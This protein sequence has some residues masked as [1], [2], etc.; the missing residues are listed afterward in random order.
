MVAGYA[1]KMPDAY[2]DEVI[3]WWAGGPALMSRKEA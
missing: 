2:R 1:K 3:A